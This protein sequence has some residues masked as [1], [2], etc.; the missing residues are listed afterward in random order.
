MQINILLRNQ[1]SCNILFAYEIKFKVI[2]TVINIDISF[3][4]V[5]PL[6]DTEYNFTLNLFYF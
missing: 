5:Q 6:C 4:C 2:Y 1:M 3:F